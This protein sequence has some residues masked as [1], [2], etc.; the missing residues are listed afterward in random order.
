MGNQ[1]KAV[2]IWI[3]VSTEDQANGES[4]EHHE[5]RARFYAEAKGWNVVEVYHLEAL[6]GKSVM[7]YPQTKKMLEDIRS[8]RITGLIFSKLAR[9]ARNTRELLDFAD[10]FRDEE[11]DL[12]SLQEAIDT[13]SPAGRL[14]YTMIA[15]MAQWEREEISSRVAASVPIRAKLGKHLGGQASL[16]YKWE[17][18]ELVLDEQFGPVR[19]LVYE[20]FLKL[21]R[22]KAVARELNKLGFRTRNGSEFSDTTVVRLIRDPNAKGIRR[23]NYTRSQGD[24]KRWN[25]KPA[26][27][28]VYTPCPVLVTEEVWNEC[29]QILDATEAKYKR[30]GPRAKHLLSGYVQCTCGKSM[31]VYHET[32]SNT[33]SCKP[34]KTRIHEADL[35]EIFQ[36]QLKTFLLTDVSISD[37]LEKVDQTIQEKRDLLSTVVSERAVLTKKVNGLVDMRAMG[38]MAREAFARQYKPL[39]ERLLQLEEQLPELEA[40]IDFLTMQHRSSDV[41]LHEARDLYSQWGTLEFDHKR[42]IVEVITESITVGKEDIHIKLSYMPHQAPRAPLPNGGNKQR[43]FIPALAFFGTEIV[44]TQS[45]KAGVVAIENLQTIGEHI[46]KRRR[47]LGLLQKDLAARFGVCEDTI[48]GWENNRCAPRIQHYPKLI[49]FLGYNPFPQDENTLG[50]RIQ[51]YRSERGISQKKFAQMMQVDKSTVRSWERNEH[52]PI[53]AATLALL[54]QV[55]IQA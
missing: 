41:V 32:K 8:K 45:L 47:E 23:A 15:A 4:P 54:E 21:K 9:L 39:E 25:L 3:R 20:L 17:N 35:D 31:Y 48:T 53:C 19:K 5:K 22:K 34:C 42:S 29:N 2:G 51:K 55:I 49:E 28:W 6:S 12:I 7:S 26:D 46:K 40:E 14:F 52:R 13:S 10:I 30:L 36:E 27:E 33:Y 43:N 38:E 16:G 18:S 44:D 11:A 24:G 50:G 37:Y 1:Q